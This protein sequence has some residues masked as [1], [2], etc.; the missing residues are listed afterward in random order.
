MFKKKASHKCEAFV[1]TNGFE[2][3]TLPTCGRDA[4][5]LPIK[6]GRAKLWQLT[7][8]LKICFSNF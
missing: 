4:L 1:G 2:P 3:L 6:I 7:F 8:Q 5:N